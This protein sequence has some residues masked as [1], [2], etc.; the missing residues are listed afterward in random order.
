LAD[1]LTSFKGP[2]HMAVSAK[3]V[4]KLQT[5]SSPTIHGQRFG[6]AS[7]RSSLSEAPMVV[8]Q[9]VVMQRFTRLTR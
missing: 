7:T 9:T 2:T 6:R 1:P 4:Q 3:T 5:I 8:H